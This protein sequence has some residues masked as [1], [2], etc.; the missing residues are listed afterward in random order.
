MNQMLTVFLPHLVGVLGFFAILALG[1]H[2][3]WPAL[4]STLLLFAMLFLLGVGFVPSPW[5]RLSATANAPHLAPTTAILL[6]F[7]YEEDGDTMRPGAANQFLVDWL[8]STHPQVQTMLVQEG[9][10]S[11][12][13]PEL[14]ANKEIRRIHRHDKT[15]YVDTLD[16]AFCALQEVQKLGAHP[17]LL[18]AH[19]LQ[20]QRA[21]WDFA[22][23]RQAACAQCTVVAAAMPDTPYPAASVHWQTHNEFIYKLVELLVLR[24]RDF[25]RATPTNCKAPL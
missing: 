1:W 8:F 21:V 9:I 19:D 15:I 7:G 23:V 5:L 10:Y 4:L 22:R 17:V 25:L 14:L 16:T 6:G 12:I 3:S 2:M 20:L 24:P 13:T 11:A 18:V